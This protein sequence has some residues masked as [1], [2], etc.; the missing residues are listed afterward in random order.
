[1]ILTVYSIA[2]SRQ[3]FAVLMTNPP[4]FPKLPTVCGISYNYRCM[5]CMLCTCY[6]IF[7]SLT[8]SLIISYPCT[9]FTIQVQYYKEHIYCMKST[10]KQLYFL[11]S[12]FTNLL[13]GY[14]CKWFNFWKDI[15][16]IHW[17]FDLS[18]SNFWWI[19]YVSQCLSC[20]TLKKLWKN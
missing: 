17:M 18:S 9:F 15:W 20:L 10:I 7:L 2:W 12:Y 19:I 14:P 3:L 1:M 6:I 16:G 13:T 5:I 4:K 11:V 8:L